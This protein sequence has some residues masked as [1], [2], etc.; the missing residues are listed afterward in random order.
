M[1][2]CV[3]SGLNVFGIGIGI[4]PVRIEYLFQ[5]NIIVITH[6]I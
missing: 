6:I 4:Y 2:S 3:K 5:K 1:S